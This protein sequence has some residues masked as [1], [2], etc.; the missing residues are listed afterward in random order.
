M[1]WEQS[2]QQRTIATSRS[3]DNRVELQKSD[4]P[5]ATLARLAAK[6]KAQKR[7]QEQATTPGATAT[8]QPRGNRIQLDGLFQEGPLDRS[9]VAHSLRRG[10]GPPRKIT[11]LT[12]GN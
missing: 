10:G 12:I 6:Q 11:W 8:H 5:T 2:R 7:P 1:F 4:S 3:D 9:W